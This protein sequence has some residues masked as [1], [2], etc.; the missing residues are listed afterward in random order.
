MPRYLYRSS[1]EPA[2]SSSSSIAHGY[3]SLPLSF[4]L[5]AGGRIYLA[6]SGPKCRAAVLALC[7][8]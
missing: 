6:L 7:L 2:S 4:Q 3:Y 1:H 5:R 8:R